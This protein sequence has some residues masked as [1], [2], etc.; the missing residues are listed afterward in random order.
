MKYLIPFLFLFASCSTDVQGHPRVTDSDTPSEDT[1]PES[2]PE[3]TASDSSTESLSNEEETDSSI[4]T[5]MWTCL[6][7]G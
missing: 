1:L 7:C 5:K 3:E 4:Y 2:T 6:I